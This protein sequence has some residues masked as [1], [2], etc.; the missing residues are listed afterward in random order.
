MP[1]GWRVRVTD[2]RGFTVNSGSGGWLAVFGFYGRTQRTPALIPGQVQLLAAL[3]AGREDA[4]QTVILA[5]DRDGT[6]VAKPTPADAA[7]PS[8]AP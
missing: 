6:Y 2:E 5:D 3:L 8:K 1:P 4:V 7:E